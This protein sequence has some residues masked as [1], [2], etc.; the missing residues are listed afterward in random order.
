MNYAFLLFS[1]FC[2]LNCFGQTSVPLKETG[3]SLEEIIPPNWKLLDYE[4]GD[5]NKDGIND[6]VFAI[7]ETDSSKM[8]SHEGIGTSTI[9]LNTRILGIYFGTEAGIY[10]Q[11]FLS[12]TFIL[13]RDSPTMDEPFE[14]FKISEKG[15]LEISFRFWYS[16]GSWSTSYHK[17]KFRFEE[18]KFVL[19][20]Y[21]FQEA[22]RGSGSTIDYSINF[23]S[24]KMKITKSSFANDDPATVE[25]RTFNLLE[26]LTI[27]KM[28]APFET[29]FEGFYL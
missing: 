5:L 24:N 7:Q 8:E 23:L 13:L 14:G 18:N 1:F 19:I 3:K 20:G 12:D 4:H 22:H 26:K 25:W 21:D 11:K 27:E 16:A 9:D 15:V 17:Y 28:K 2:L 10:E 6:I 29:A